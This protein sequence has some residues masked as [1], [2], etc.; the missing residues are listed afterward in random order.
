MKHRKYTKKLVKSIYYL[1]EYYT[2]RE[3]GKMLGMHFANVRRVLHKFGYTNTNKRRYKYGRFD[4]LT[5]SEKGYM[6]GIIDGEGHITPKCRIQVANTNYEVLIWLKDKLGGS[7]SKRNTCE[8]NHK[9]IW[10]WSLS[11]VPSRGLI[12]SILPYLIIKKERALIL[13]SDWKKLKSEYNWT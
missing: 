8:K 5:E 1:L 2:F 7:I 10:C 6:A 12:L 9:P 13:L 4:Y 11:Y 3:L